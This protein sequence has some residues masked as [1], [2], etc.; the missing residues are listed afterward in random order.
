MAEAA[1]ATVGDLSV[2]EFTRDYLD[3]WNS[4]EPDRLLALMAPD[5][6]YD[7]SGWPRTMR[8]HADVREFVEHAWTAFP[9]LRFELLEGPYL[10]GENKSAFWWRGTG[11]LTGP[12]APPGF[13]PTGKRF[14][15]DGADFHEYRDGRVGRLRIVFDV[16]GASQQLGLVPLPGSRAERLAVAVQRLGRRFARS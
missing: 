4:H 14:D 3:A 10:L 13:A 15:I 6:V 16:N 11:T 1:V 5:I 7:D 9:D 2:E 8:S 12:L